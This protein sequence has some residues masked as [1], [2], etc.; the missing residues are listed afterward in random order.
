[1]EEEV[2]VT[3]NGTKSDFALVSEYIRALSE[4]ELLEPEEQEF[5]IQFLDSFDKTVEAA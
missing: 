2:E 5:L 1:M 3:I 4:G